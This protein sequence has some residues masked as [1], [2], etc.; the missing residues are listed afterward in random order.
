MQPVD[1]TA[2]RVGG[3]VRRRPAGEYGIQGVGQVVDGGLIAL[4]AEIGDAIVDA[5][6]VHELA[7]RREDGSLRRDCRAGEI[8]QF[9][10]NAIQ[11]AK[12]LHAILTLE[13][14]GLVPLTQTDMNIAAAEELTRTEAEMN[15]LLSKIEARVKEVDSRPISIPG[16]E[17]DSSWLD[18]LKDAQEKWLAYRKAHCEFDTYLN[19]GGTIRSLLWGKEATRLT[20]L[21]ISDLE[22]WLRQDSER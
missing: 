3:G 18:H 15:K 10:D 2:D 14:F 19:R 20:H 7:S 8:D 1:G 13:K 21:R 11:L 5:P 4:L 9:L 17:S 12:A 16:Y 22:S 6:Q